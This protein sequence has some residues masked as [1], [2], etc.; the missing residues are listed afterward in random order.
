MKIRPE[1]VSEII[2]KEIENYKKSLDVKTSGTVL[3]VGDGIARIYGLSS[4]MS[5]ELLEFPNGVMG[6]AMNL[7]KNNVGAVILGNASLIK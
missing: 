2:K 7:E 1:E 5:N 6:M 4:V 3:E